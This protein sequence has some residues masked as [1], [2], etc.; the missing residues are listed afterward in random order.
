MNSSERQSATKVLKELLGALSVNPP[1]ALEIDTRA[2]LPE[3]QP[4]FILMVASGG[5]GA[6]FSR[7]ED[8]RDTITLFVQGVV[9]PSQFRDV[10]LARKSSFVHEFIHLMD[11]RGIDPKDVVMAGSSDK[12][13]FTHP[14]EIRAYVHQGLF[15]LEDELENTSKAQL[16]KKYGT[17]FET[18]VKAAGRVFHPKLLQHATQET[19]AMIKS[20]LEE[21]FETYKALTS[22]GSVSLYEFVFNAGKDRDW[23]TRAKQVLVFSPNDKYEVEGNTHDGISHAIKHAH[24]F[25]PGEV[26]ALLQQFSAALQPKTTAAKT[27]SG[28]T[29]SDPSKVSSYMHDTGV[30]LNTLDRIND[31]VKTGAS[32][33]AAE[34]VGHKAAEKMFTLYNKVADSVISGSVPV[35][36]V[37]DVGQLVAL[38]SSGK[39]IRFTA[40]FRGHKGHVYVFDHKTRALASLR[41]NG[42]LNTLFKLTPGK[43]VGAYVSSLGEIENPIVAQFLKDNG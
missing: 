42:D 20:G 5:G 10:L 13:Q 17:T 2:I 16:Q 1:N 43:N 34:T 12:E 25:F 11:Y 28:A 40:S 3:L 35:D 14:S 38:V 24:E 21:V 30:L 22:P 6:K 23:P 4:D 41:D 26:D 15:E 29:V 39:P 27:M 32:L 19:K 36:G 33:T 7:R 31:K 37:K 18:F 9:K 8:G